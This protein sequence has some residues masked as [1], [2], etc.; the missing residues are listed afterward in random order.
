MSIGITAKLSQYT[1]GYP[2]GSPTP[3]LREAALKHPHS[4]HVKQGVPRIMTPPST[5]VSDDRPNRSAAPTPSHDNPK[6]NY[7]SIPPANKSV[8]EQLR[9]NNPLKDCVYID[10]HIRSNSKSIQMPCK[11]IEYGA[12]PGLSFEHGKHI[13]SFHIHTEFRSLGD[14]KKTYG[15]LV[16]K[17]IKQSL[18]SNILH[19][20]NE[21]RFG[22]DATAPS[23]TRGL[24]KAW[25]IRFTNPN[26]GDED[27]RLSDDSWNTKL[28]P[29]S[30]S[31]IHSGTIIMHTSSSVL[32]NPQT[33]LKNI[34][35]LRN[36]S[37]MYHFFKNCGTNLEPGGNV[38]VILKPKFAERWNVL[39]M[40]HALGFSEAQSPQIFQLGHAHVRTQDDR[41]V[42][43]E[44]QNDYLYLF[45][46][47]NTYALSPTFSEFCQYTFPDIGDIQLS[48][49]FQMGL[50]VLQEKDVKGTRTDSP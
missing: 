13:N 37:L 6:F 5:P 27:L 38:E 12:G 50:M 29:S 10:P 23:S 34:S 28:F 3:S 31:W 47:N 36:M 8:I 11:R 46:K 15:E 49:D 2:P 18:S 26:L 19:G 16:P 30:S 7:P 14:I 20:T 22:I 45:K 44:T 24:G 39:P 41:K 21:M 32:Q 9:Y 35:A 48:S 1:M 33:R 4:K 25:Y 43:H 40:A 17:S 42:S